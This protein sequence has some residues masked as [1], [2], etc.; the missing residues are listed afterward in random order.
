MSLSQTP[1]LP[2]TLARILSV[3]P[4]LI[5]VFVCRYALRKL[6]HYCSLSLPISII[7]RAE[8]RWLKPPSQLSF[9]GLSP[10]MWLAQ[11]VDNFSPA[12]L[13]GTLRKD[14]PNVLRGHNRGGGSWKGTLYPLMEMY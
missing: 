9:K 1:S 7:Y 11:V 8:W 5:L 12:T 2:L 13:T 14:A 6:S 3:N 10:G 4:P